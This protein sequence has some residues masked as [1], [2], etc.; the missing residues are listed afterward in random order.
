MGMIEPPESGAMSS[1]WVNR[2]AE[3]VRNVTHG[4]AFS[5]RGEAMENY[6]G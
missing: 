6:N 1:T 4:Q 2:F 5:S 3:V